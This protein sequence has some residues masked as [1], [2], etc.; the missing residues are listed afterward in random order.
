MS[1]SKLKVLPKRKDTPLQVNVKNGILTIQIGIDTLAWCFEREPSYQTEENEPTRKVTN[2]EG[3]ARDVII[4][5]CHEEEN[6]QTPLNQFLDDMCEYACEQ[7]G[8]EY[9]DVIMDGEKPRQRYYSE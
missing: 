4:A 2:N 3:F 8:S 6:G 1:N 5:M 9:V 7:D